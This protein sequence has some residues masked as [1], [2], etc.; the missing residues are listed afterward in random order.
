[1]YRMPRGLSKYQKRKA[2]LLGGMV[3]MTPETVKKAEETAEQKVEKKMEQ[4]VKQDRKKLFQAWTK[5]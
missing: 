2:Q 5:F 3:Q 4:E 1:M